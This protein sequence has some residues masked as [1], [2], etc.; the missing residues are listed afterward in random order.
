MRGENSQ[1]A[2][3][4]IILCDSGHING[5]LI[6]CARYRI[7]DMRAKDLLSQLAESQSGHVTHVLF[8]IN[9]PVQAVQSSF[10]GFQGDPW[11]SCHIDELR[12]SEKGAITL[13]G[14]QG[15]TISEL[16][17]GGPEQRRR[18]EPVLERQVSDFTSSVEG[19]VFERMR[20]EE[21]GWGEVEME[22]GREVEGDMQVMDIENEEETK[23]SSDSGEEE[24]PMEEPMEERERVSEEDD[25]TD[26]EGPLRSA[27][28][29][30][31]MQED[32]AA[33]NTERVVLGE[34]FSEMCK[35][36]VRLNS[37]IQAAAS[38]LQDSMLNKQ[39][40]AERV[41]LLI[42]F[43]PL[44]P[45]FPL[46]MWWASHLVLLLCSVYCVAMIPRPAFIAYSHVNVTMECALFASGV[47]RF[48]RQAFLD[49]LCYKCNIIL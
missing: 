13:E 30:T 3:L 47:L 2:C 11:V 40:A 25:I 38:R 12:A 14:A 6:A 28:S 34:K 36:C 42:K 41:K 23:S 26:K 1:G 49:F 21:G 18:R 24:K 45:L 43:I 32:E 16:F 22:E 4:L 35:Q 10:V 46:G 39:R 19:M 33:V 17:Y 5:D 7:Y 8:I 48:I 9:L 15:I 44:K 37:C 20:S 29:V 31:V 27:G